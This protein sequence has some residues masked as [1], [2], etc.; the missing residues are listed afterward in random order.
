MIKICK[1]GRI[2][3]QNN[4]EADS[5]LGILTSGRHTPY[6]KKGCPETHWWRA[7]SVFKKG[8]TPWMK[9]KHHAANAKKK[10]G[11]AAKDRIPW[12]QG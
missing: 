9:D 4:K 6:L 8:H 3:G 10:I 12:I 7:G 11:K 5:H 2:W 1:D